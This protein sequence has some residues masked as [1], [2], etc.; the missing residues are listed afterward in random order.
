MNTNLPINDKKEEIVK[1]V[2]NFDTVILTAETGSGKSTQ[3]PQFL[4]EAGYKVIV[5]Q[6]RRIACITLAE[7][8]DEEMHDDSWS[9]Y[10][11]GVVGYHT[12]FESTRTEKTEILFCT[13]GL[14][15][16]KGI[17]KNEKTV[18]I[19]DEVHEW[20]LNI[21]TLVAWIKKFRTDNNSIKVVLMSAT[22][23]SNE[24]EKFYAENSSVTT[25]SIEGRYHKVEMIQDSS[26]DF[27]SRICEFAE[28]GRNVLAFAP[29][30][31]EIND[32]IDELK[33][34]MEDHQVII[35][36]LHSELSAKEQ[37]A[38]FKQYS[39]TKIVVATNIAQTSVTIPDIDAVVDL[40]TEK[41]IEVHNGI[42]GLFI[43]NISKA[44]CLQRAGRA[45]R[46][47]DGKY[48]LCSYYTLDDRDEFSTPEIQRLIID[49][50]VLKLASVNIDAAELDFFHQ[51]SKESIIESK[52]VLKMLGALKHNQITAVG[53]RMVKFP[54]SV[55]SAKMILTAE[56]LGCVDDILKI[57]SIIEVGSLIDYRAEKE[58]KSTWLDLSFTEK[59]KY[60]DFT[61]E[62]KSDLLAELDIFDQICSYKYPD[63]R[64][65]G[66]NKKN[67]HR[68][69]EYYEKLN[70]NLESLD[71]IEFNNQSTDRFD[72]IKSIV[73]GISDNLY[74][75]GWGNDAFDS[76]GNNY[77]LCKST[78][79]SDSNS[80]VVGYPKIIT[81]KDRWGYIQTMTIL[82]NSSA[83]SRDQLVEIVGEDN[84]ESRR[85]TDDIT[86]NY[87][88]DTFIV[89]YA[90]SY[91]GF[92]LGTKYDEV[93]G[94]DPIYKE[95]ADNTDL[96][97]KENDK[98]VIING[99]LYKVEENYFSGPAIYINNEKDILNS[100]IRTHRM[101]DGKFVTF[102][103]GMWKNVN[104]DI[105]RQRIINN[106]INN[107]REK[108][109]YNLP[110]GRSGSTKV[111]IEEYLPKLGKIDF[112]I[113]QYGIEEFIWVGLKLSKESAYL[114]TFNS[115]NDAT[116][117]TND[118]LKF[119]I[120]KTAKQKYNDKNFRIKGSIGKK[121]ET[122]RTKS[123][124]EEFHEYLREII[125]DT[126]VENF[127]D[128]LEFLEEVY[129][130]CI[131]SMTD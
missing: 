96:I 34:R 31:K 50:V 44:D 103:Y 126:T 65:V 5:T 121:I 62:D 82:N 115:E 6:P 40:G 59:I 128:N 66:L 125:R 19:L 120:S 12:A 72:I 76:E 48:V 11:D 80:F 38:C 16:A 24:L 53:K 55:R 84:I 70:G 27:I 100:D 92:N 89:P 63:L 26:Y 18:L 43:H 108:L 56:E 79:I 60:S 28:S 117:S 36:P 83:V 131:K 122:K 77:K 39:E 94:S 35:L 30:K 87:D 15:M 21:E 116:E 33:Q 14:Q 64:K 129:N 42:E 45:G 51:P 127:T 71:L 8:V 17:K 85:I 109:I 104:L 13:D 93:L 49:K 110:Q 86:Y 99:H 119:F 2:N 112:S 130:E 20:N 102:F 123:A 118:T 47:K 73:S 1:A 52:K 69:K 46:T 124:K 57:T 90:R 111:I 67:F 91:R 32:T 29:G 3:V 101:I 106:E 74:R 97:Q 23:E 75:L 54:V 37:N 107:A 78:C 10:W 58:V 95:L 113:P 98:I 22:M 105:I 9:K 88:N 68:I 7:R 61:K 81:Y 41:R 4:Y 25:I 114:A